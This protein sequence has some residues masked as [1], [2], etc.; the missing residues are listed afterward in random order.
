MLFL[1]VRKFKS[2]LLMELNR[3]KVVLILRVW[4]GNLLILFSE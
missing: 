3:L 1:R 2:V 4:I